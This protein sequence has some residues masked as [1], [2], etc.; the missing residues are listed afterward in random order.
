[1]PSPFANDPNHWR[2]RAEEMRALAEE[3]KDAV[4]RTTMLKIANDYDK[5]ADRAEKRS[6]GAGSK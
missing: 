2:H 6:D 5:L 1:M 3:M 4:A